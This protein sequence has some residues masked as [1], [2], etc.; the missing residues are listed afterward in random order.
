VRTAIPQ[1]LQN[2]NS[3][4]KPLLFLVLALATDPVAVDVPASELLPPAVGEVSAVGDVSM[5]EELPVLIAASVTSPALVKTSPVRSTK[6]LD[7]FSSTVAEETCLCSTSALF[8]ACPIEVKQKSCAFNG[9][10]NHAPGQ[11]TLL[12]PLTEKVV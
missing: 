4:F 7:E 8:A 12:V 3:N 11:H 6:T 5:V 9:V 10:V 1:V 2:H